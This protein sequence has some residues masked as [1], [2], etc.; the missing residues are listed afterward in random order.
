MANPRQ[1]RILIA[2]DHD[3]VRQGMR[4]IL[5]REPDWT[6]CG[7]AATGRQALAL[8]FELKP[9]LM[10]VDIGL[11]EMSGLEVTRRVRQTLPVK[12]LI[13]TMNDA[14]KVVQE[15]MSAGANGYMLKA[16]AGRTLREAVQAILRHGE[17]LS[18]GVRAAAEVARGTPERLSPRE[19]EV[20]PLLAEGRTNKEIA[21]ILN[22]STKTVETH[23]ARI[24]ARLE[25][26]SM[27]ELVRYAIRN[28]VIEP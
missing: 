11:P 26:H 7:E 15:A 25:V 2:D 8:A 16:E 17:F 21:T 14:D 27:S 9:D 6:V 22:I 23:R 10:V 3:L 28:K 12:V 18:E 1:V 24:M 4:A 5:E 20:L 19:R 13:V